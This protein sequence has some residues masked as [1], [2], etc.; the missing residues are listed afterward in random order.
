MRKHTYF[1]L[2]FLIIFLD[3]YFVAAINNYWIELLVL[4]IVCGGTAG[5]LYAKILNECRKEAIKETLKTM[6][7]VEIGTALNEKENNEQ[8]KET[9]E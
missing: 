4:P 1:T 3:G 9:M 6:I 8:S 2:F 5:W 7:E